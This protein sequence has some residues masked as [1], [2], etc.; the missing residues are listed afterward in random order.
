MKRLITLLVSGILGAGVSN[1][2]TAL[3]NLSDLAGDGVS[4]AAGVPAE[5]VAAPVLEKT[6]APAPGTD[7]NAVDAAELKNL[8]C[9]NDLLSEE[10]GEYAGRLSGRKLLIGF[11]DGSTYQLAF[12]SNAFGIVTA[13]C[14][15]IDGREVYRDMPLRKCADKRG[16]FRYLEAFKDKVSAAGTYKYAVH[17]LIPADLKLLEGKTLRSFA[18]LRWGYWRQTLLAEKQADVH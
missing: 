3:S 4:A 11:T 13:S 9:S 1:A 8:T 14:S 12:R 5:A 15:D 7:I 2:G 6:N 17:I 16:S 10:A 18:D